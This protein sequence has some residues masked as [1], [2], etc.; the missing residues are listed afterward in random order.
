MRRS[1]ALMGL[2]LV[3]ALSLV[4]SAQ[5]PT[6]TRSPRADL[7][8]RLRTA[9]RLGTGYVPGR[10]LVKF[11]PGLPTQAQT[12]AVT[13][14]LPGT[15][16][17]LRAGDVYTD[18]TYVEVPLDADVPALA[19]TLAARP[20][21]EYAEPDAIRHMDVTP[22]DPSFGRQWNMRAMNLERAWDIN[23]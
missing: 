7:R 4:L 21:V 13:Q 10:M 19:A 14:A 1:V 2:V 8:V 16:V 23:D 11:R 5:G 15:A 18:F 20:E 17:A 22:T 9:A 12:S 6:F 3:T